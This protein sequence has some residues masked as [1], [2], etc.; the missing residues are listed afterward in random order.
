MVSGPAAADAVERARR[1]R[2]LRVGLHLVLVD[3]LP[4]L[5]AQQIPDLVDSAGRLRSDLAALGARIFLRRGARAQLAAE[6]D[7][8]FAAF[9]ATGLALDHVNAHH[10]FHVHPTVAAAV[11]RVGRRHGLRALR[12]PR[13]PPAGLDAAD[14]RRHHRRDWRMAPWIAL[15]A[16]RARRQAI[17]IPDRVFGLAWSGE[18]TEPRL[19]GVLRA[20]PDGV[21]EIYTHIA[22][23]DEFPGATPGYRYRDE[24]HALLS[25]AIVDLVHAT[26]AC[27]G[28]FADIGSR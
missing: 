9:A 22:T 3:G 11:L 4:T 10:H 8:Q 27:I 6:I 15:L 16:R 18:M 26:Q 12:V 1:L 13:E 28:G 24:L 17:A 14:A 19:A 7:A 20:L 21:S 25:P 23:A 2:S 5:P